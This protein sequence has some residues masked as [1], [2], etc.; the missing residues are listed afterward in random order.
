MQENMDFNYKLD[1]FVFD[2]NRITVLSILFERSRGERELQGALKQSQ[3][4]FNVSTDGKITTLPQEAI[5]RTLENTKQVCVSTLINMSVH[6]FL[7]FSSMREK[8][9]RRT[10]SHTEVLQT[11]GPVY[12][13]TRLCIS[14]MFNRLSVII[15]RLFKQSMTVGTHS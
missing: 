15:L 4:V 3:V 12:A 14:V 1:H 9:D 13:N 2:K 6:N 8:N 10:K 11:L 5:T 7:S